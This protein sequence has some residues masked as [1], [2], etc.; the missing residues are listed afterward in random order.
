MDGTIPTY[1]ALAAQRLHL[2]TA[3][4]YASAQSRSKVSQVGSDL[5]EEPQTFYFYFFYQQANPFQ[6]RTG[7]GK[8]AILDAGR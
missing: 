2:G 7:A 6:K 4:L 1:K 3:A 5:V 8:D